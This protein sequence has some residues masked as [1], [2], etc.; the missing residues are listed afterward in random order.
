[1]KR[2]MDETGILGQVA[3]C[4][5]DDGLA[6]LYTAYKRLWSDLA[7]ETQPISAIHI[8]L[9]GIFYALGAKLPSKKHCWVF[10]DDPI[11]WLI[12]KTSFPKTSFPK[13]SFPVKEAERD[14][15]KE[16][17]ELLVPRARATAFLRS[18]WA[19]TGDPD[20]LH[21]SWIDALI[22]YVANPDEQQHPCVRLFAAH[23]QKST[24][25]YEGAI[26][27]TTDDDSEIS[28]YHKIGCWASFDSGNASIR[29]AR[30]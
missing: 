6:R 2:L 28:I 3:P 23:C 20:V 24:E 8:K 27:R 11:R 18:Q 22:P 14:K 1:M 16:T 13:T 19:A 15:Q 17:M 26:L 9:T 4:S 21:C 5:P 30:G 12:D 10:Q 7:D 29:S 25:A